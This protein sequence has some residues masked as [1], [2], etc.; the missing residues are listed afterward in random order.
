MLEY[1]QKLIQDLKNKSS[2]GNMSLKFVQSLLEMEDTNKWLKF[3]ATTPEQMQRVQRF[4]DNMQKLKEKLYV[5]DY[6][7][8]NV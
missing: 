5:P 1:Y 3:N 8:E 4:E 7:S 2:K 6:Q